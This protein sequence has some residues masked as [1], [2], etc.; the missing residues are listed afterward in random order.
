MKRR[1]LIQGMAGCIACAAVFAS[2]ARAQSAWQ[3]PPRFA[4]PDIASDEGGLWAIMDRAEARLRQSPFALRDERFSKYMQAIACRIAGSHCPDLR[5]HV[6][7]TP[8]F[9]AS[10]AP[11][12]MMQVWTGLLL[13]CDNEAQLAAVLG[14]EIGHYLQRHSIERLRDTKAR[15][16]F[17]RFLGLFGVVGTLGSAGVIASAMAYSRDQEREA[18]SIGITLMREA[19]YDSAEASQIWGN[20]LLELQARQGG[21]ASN[22]NP[23]FATHPSVDERKTTLAQLA[24]A[25]PGGETREAA[26]LDETRRLR[27]G[28]LADE[29]KRG[30]HEESL[31]LFTRMH[32]RQPQADVLWARGEVYRLRDKDKDADAALADYQAAI[33]LNAEPAEVHRGAGLIY[34]MRQQGEQARASFQRYLELAPAA[35]DAPMIKSYMEALGT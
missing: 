25:S 13:R 12:G 6:V 24:A 23:L 2:G 7:H 33:A 31:A 28:W 4:R 14:H 10:I 16:A 11:N 32:D 18:D 17:A 9:N 35:P 22:T 15:T 20:L 27:H 8:Y 34:R 29:I 3:R 19:G 5:V 21:A 1:A 26:W 30:Q